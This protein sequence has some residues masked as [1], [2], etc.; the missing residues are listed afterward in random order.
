MPIYV[1]LEKIDRSLL[2]AAADLG[3]SAFKRFCRI[4]FPLSFPGVLAA[5]LI[6]FIPT[7]GDYITPK[8][9]GGSEG[10]MVANLIQIMFGKANNW[11]LGSSIA[12]ITMIIVTLSVILFVLI[13]RWLISKIK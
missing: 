9:V 10:I 1:S 7:T 11:P 3:D 13:S 4:T 5:S 8:L 6:I 12:V 2:E